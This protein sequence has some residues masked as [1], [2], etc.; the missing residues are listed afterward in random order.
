MTEFGPDDAPVAVPPPEAMGSGMPAGVVRRLPWV[1]VV[2]VVAACLVFGR[3]Q[4]GGFDHSVVIDI[5]WRLMLGQRPYVDFPCTVPVWWMEGIGV[6]FRML[7]PSWWTVV[8]LQAVF[9]GVTCGWSYWLL[10]KIR[11]DPLRSFVI[12]LALQSG[13]NLVTSYWW[14]NPLTTT[15]V[16]INHLSLVA[17]ARHPRRLSCNASCVIAIALLAGCKPNAAAPLLIMSGPLLVIATGSF[18]RAGVIAVAAATFVWLGLAVA[19]ISPVQVISSYRDVAGRGLTLDTLRD[20]VGSAARRQEVA[21]VDV[22]LESC[23]LLA[24]VQF[25]FLGGWKTCAGLAAAGTWAAGIVAV[26]TNGEHKLVDATIVLC[27]TVATTAAQAAA[28]STGADRAS[29]IAKAVHRGSTAL[30]LLWIGYGLAVSANR[31]RVRAIGPFYAPTL[32]AQ[33]PATPFFAAL[34]ASDEFIVIEKEL[35]AVLREMEPASVYFGPRLQ[36]AYAA[37][38]IPSPRYEPVWWHRGVSYA[39]GKEAD[40]VAAWRENSHDVM[41]FYPG[42]EGMSYIPS[43]MLSDFEKQCEHVFSNTLVV[44]VRHA[45]ADAL[46]AAES[47]R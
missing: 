27:A 6:A 24:V 38:G 16:C 8:V 15:A 17:L 9:A 7:G 21:S 30:C 37:F 5:G 36:W 46:R 25:A 39:T 20:L 23:L 35:A 47:R 40:M 45:K 43:D 19:G 26:L 18:R 31:D 3:R 14:Y 11:P 4:F 12:A 10:E 29:W 32:S 2:F 42:E 34:Q 22:L 44:F 28:T 13:A 33:R 1:A 41:I